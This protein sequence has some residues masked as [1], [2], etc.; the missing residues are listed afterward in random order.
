MGWGINC[1]HRDTTCK[2]YY[3]IEGLKE[4]EGSVRSQTPLTP[5]PSHVT[6]NSNLLF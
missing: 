4:T 2:I 6:R 1:T 3:K 5:S